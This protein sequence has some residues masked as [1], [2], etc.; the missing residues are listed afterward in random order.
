VDSRPLTAWAGSLWAAGRRTVYQPEA[1][2]VRI[3]EPPDRPGSID[4]A[5]EAWAPVLELRPP[6]PRELDVAAWRSL[7]ARDDV[8]GAWQAARQRA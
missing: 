1:V 4:A 6:R 5:A 7:L 3:G 2:A 8:A